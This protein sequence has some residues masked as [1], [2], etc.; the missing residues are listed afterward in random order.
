MT[1]LTMKS[2][3]MYKSQD[4]K[5]NIRKIVA[6]NFFIFYQTRESVILRE[7]VYA[8]FQRMSKRQRN[9]NIKN[10]VMLTWR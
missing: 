2:R 3:I 7:M 8:H 9:L 1:S 6:D 10:F 5:F 4:I